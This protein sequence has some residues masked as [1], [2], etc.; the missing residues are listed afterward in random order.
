MTALYMVLNSN[1]VRCKMLS[2]QHTNYCKYI[3][4]VKRMID[5]I[6]KHQTEVVIM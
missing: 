5:N 2:I 6:A 4:T 1:D 3:Y